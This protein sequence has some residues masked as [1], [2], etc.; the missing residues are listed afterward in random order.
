MATCEPCARALPA[1]RP[2]A[3]GGFSY[4]L[5]LAVVAIVGMMLGQTGLLWKTE[6]QRIKEAELLF[7]GDQYRRAIERYLNAQPA[8]PRFPPDLAA[9]IQDD[10]FPDTR[11]YLRRLQAD[12]L[13]PEVEWGL[14][15][16]PQTR[17]VMGVFSKSAGR[18]LKRDN[19]KSPYQQFKDAQS[20]ADWKF[21]VPA[22]EVKK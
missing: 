14:I 11:R 8:A 2:R 22:P 15:I 20:Y 6:S 10:R 9:L 19:F 12:P 1:R 13:A 5:A 7:I 17:G 4:L 3:Q 16:D 21:F 18:P